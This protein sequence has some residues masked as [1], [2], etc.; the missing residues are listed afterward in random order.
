MFYREIIRPKRW[1]IISKGQGLPTEGNGEDFNSGVSEPLIPAGQV[2]EG[3][4]LGVREKGTLDGG[5]GWGW[6]CCGARE[7]TR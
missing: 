1:E 4:W 2:T 6:G 3:R 7:A 5:W